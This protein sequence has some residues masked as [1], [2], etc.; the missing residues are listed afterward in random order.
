MATISPT[1][2]TN[3]TPAI[4]VTM[5]GAI[6]Y[7]EFT[8]VVG[9]YVYQV[10]RIVLEALATRQINEP[11]NYNIYNA[12]GLAN[13]EPLKPKIDPYQK[14]ATY[15]LPTARKRIILN[16]FSSLGFIIH[17]GETVTME[18][19]SDQRSVLDELDKLG[20]TNF[21]RVSDKLDLLKMFRTQQRD[22]KK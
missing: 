14:Q 8:N 3:S 6:T 21:E 15:E 12:S 11:I 20:K 1:I 2:I 5:L 10:Y 9:T 13:Q 22:C 16:G 4:Q 18:L 19:C 17:S 7:Q